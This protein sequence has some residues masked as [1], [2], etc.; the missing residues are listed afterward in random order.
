MRAHS[1]KCIYN[2]VVVQNTQNRRERE[3]EEADIARRIEIKTTEVNRCIEVENRREKAKADKRRQFWDQR[4]TREQN[5]A[6]AITASRLAA[7]QAE[8]EARLAANQR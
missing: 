8:T 2:P 3:R 5:E 1:I 4:A 7:E 6:G